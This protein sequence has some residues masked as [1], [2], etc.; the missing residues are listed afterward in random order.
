MLA[1][2]TSERGHQSARSATTGDAR[3]T[4]D[5]HVT[6]RQRHDREYRGDGG[7]GDRIGRGHLVEQPRHRARQAE[8][9]PQADGGSDPGEHHRPR[10]DERPDTSRRG[11]EREPDPDSARTL[12]HDAAEHTVDADGGERHGDRREEPEDEHREPPLRDRSRHGLGE[13]LEAEHRER[14]S[15]LVWGVGAGGVGLGSRGDRVYGSQS[16]AE[17]HGQFS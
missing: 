6:R 15:V 5:R 12:R 1:L 2:R 9:R 14:R 11:A 4:S 16:C 7:K 10:D 17:E 13:W 3:G 8:R